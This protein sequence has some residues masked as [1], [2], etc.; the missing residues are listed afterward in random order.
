MYREAE[1][2]M[3]HHLPKATVNSSSVETCSR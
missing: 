2:E 1:S 3:L